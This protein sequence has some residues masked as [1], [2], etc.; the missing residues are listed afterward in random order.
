MAS[1]NLS[2]PLS[3]EGLMHNIFLRDRAVLME[4]FIDGS[5]ANKHFH[6]LASWYGRKY[7][8]LTLDNPVPVD[9]LYDNIR[10]EISGMDLNS[11]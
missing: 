10:K 11:W 9:D 3:G 7:V 6:N 1:A 8:E 5:G 4:L 2:I